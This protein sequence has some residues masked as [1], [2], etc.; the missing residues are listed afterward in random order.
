MLDVSSDESDS[1][2][3]RIRRAATLQ[4]G[5][6]DDDLPERS[7]RPVLTAA[8]GQRLRPGL[9]P[10]PGKTLLVSRKYLLRRSQLLPVL[11][12]QYLSRRL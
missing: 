7:S 3:D 11:Q 10:T 12:P 2:T 4:L 1:E 6:T 9:I 5:Q 8:E